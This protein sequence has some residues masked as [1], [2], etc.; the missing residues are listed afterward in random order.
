MKKE[1]IV[2]A[3]TANM[4]LNEGKELKDSPAIRKFKEIVENIPQYTAE[5]RVKALTPRMK[6]DGLQIGDELSLIDMRE[7]G[8]GQVSGYFERV[9]DGERFNIFSVASLEFTE[10]RRI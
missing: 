8:R 10:Y 6:E 5:F 1:S 3:Y 9:E 4:F 7:E 2:K